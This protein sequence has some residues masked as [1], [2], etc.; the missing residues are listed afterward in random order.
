MA[1][2][3][4]GNDLGL[5]NSS[6]SLLGRHPGSGDPLT[7]RAGQSDGV[8]V[9]ASSGNL[10]IQRQDEYLASVGLDVSLLRTYNSQGQFDGDNN[11]NWRL[12]V[13][14]SLINLPRPTP[15]PA[16]P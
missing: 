12:G 10:V 4:T 8:Y 15:V 16:A 5:Y 3:I 1:S 6:L 13:Y 2:T 11:D 14:R 9:N 7:G